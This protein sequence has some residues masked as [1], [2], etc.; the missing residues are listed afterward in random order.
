MTIDPRVLLHTVG[1]IGG[2]V[3]RKDVSKI[4]AL[5]G[6]LESG[7]AASRFSEDDSALCSRAMPGNATPGIRSIGLSCDCWT[8]RWR[9]SLPPAASS[10]VRYWLTTMYGERMT[11][12]LSAY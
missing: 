10:C 8:R 2:I 9:P 5:E 11:G 1:T 3:R 6:A 12:G 4:A 7:A